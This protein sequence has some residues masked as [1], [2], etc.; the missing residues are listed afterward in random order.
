MPENDLVELE[1]LAVRMIEPDQ[2]PSIAL[3]EKGGTRE[4][5]VFIG[6]AEA[7]AIAFAMSRPQAPRRPMTHDALKQL[8]D[9][10][11]GRVARLVI[12]LVPEASTY[13]ADVTVVLADGT[14][15]HFD[16]RPSDAVALAVRTDPRP[17]ILAPPALLVAPPA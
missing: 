13:T 1:L 16:W 5:N 2:L 8:V 7:A 11:D 15:R 10:L 3:Q 6:P 9:A 4:L 12:G 14:E 17:A